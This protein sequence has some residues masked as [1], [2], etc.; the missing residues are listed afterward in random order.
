MCMDGVLDVICLIYSDTIWGLNDA[1]IEIG[2]LRTFL[3]YQREVIV[4]PRKEL[5][6]EMNALSLSISL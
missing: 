5:F 1:Y 6:E 2:E 3:G 4:D